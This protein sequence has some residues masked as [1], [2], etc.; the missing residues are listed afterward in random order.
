M[1]PSAWK[2]EVVRAGHGRKATVRLRKIWKK[3]VRKQER[4]S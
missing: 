4:K 1:K 3:F 2:F